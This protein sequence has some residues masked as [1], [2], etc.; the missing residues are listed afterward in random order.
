MEEVGQIS[1]R[2]GWAQHEALSHLRLGSPR[3]R[4]VMLGEVMLQ[5][6]RAALLGLSLYGLGYGHPAYAW[7]F[8]I[9]LVHSLLDGGFYRKPH[10]MGAYLLFTVVFYFHRYVMGWG[11]STTTN[12]KD[13][14]PDWVKVLKDIVWAGFVLAI[15]V[16][17]LKRPRLA[18]GTRLWSSARGRVLIILT[19]LYCLLPLANLLVRRGRLFDAVLYAVRYPL[20]YV[21]FIFLLPFVLEGRSSLRY[22]RFFIPLLVISLLFL[23]YEV[24]SGRRTGFEWGGIYIRYGSIFGSP[25]DFG[26]FL[27]LAISIVLAF[28]IERALPWSPRIMAL[29][30]VCLCALAGTVSLSAVFAMVFSGLAL[31]LFARRKLTAV[32]VVVLGAC[33]VAGLYVAFPRATVPKFLTERIENLGSLREGSAYQH[34][35]VVIDVKKEIARFAP[36]EYL[37]G[38]FNSPSFLLLPETY[39]FRTL[40]I[41]GVPSLLLLLCIIG[42]SGLEAH[43]RYRVAAGNR[44]HRGLFLGLLVGISSFAFASLF[45]P[46]FDTFPSNF[47]FWFLVAIVWSEPEPARKA[48]AI[49]TRQAAAP[50]APR[51]QLQ[52]SASSISRARRGWK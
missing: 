24:F 2:R 29:L 51:F 26:M 4:A 37:V 19:L 30:I 46:Y 35:T 38:T 52:R 45:L 6:L 48:P 8:G 16:K 41:R 14:A 47:Y 50:Q 15:A 36:A 7:L 10:L 25:N 32:L 23:A 3:P 39:Y 9:L 13:D 28:L 21:P 20:E 12:Y 43:R 42:L 44:L 1:S 27:V 11:A 31:S 18:R 17:A 34:Y 49:V 5:L 40:Y 33:L 22:L